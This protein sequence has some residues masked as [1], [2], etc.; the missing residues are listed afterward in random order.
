[1]GSEGGGGGRGGLGVEGWMRGGSGRAGYCR[2]Y[3]LLWSS[4]IE[5][6]SSTRKGYERKNEIKKPKGKYHLLRK[7]RLSAD[8]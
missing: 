5:E 4:A 3:L 2:G 1:M 7:I 8:L 6:K